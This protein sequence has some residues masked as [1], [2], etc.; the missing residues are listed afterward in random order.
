MGA[1]GKKKK[2]K[3]T[4][5]ASEQ[6]KSLQKK[7]PKPKRGKI[8]FKKKEDFPV[9]GRVESADGM[10]AHQEFISQVPP[11]SGMALAHQ[12]LRK[13]EEK[14][15]TLAEHAPDIIARFD[16]DCRHLYINSRIEEALGISR[17]NILG[18][19]QRELGYPENLVRF[20]NKKI[21]E[22]FS[23]KKEINI[24]Y[25]V[26]TPTGE[27]YFESSLVP[28]LNDRGEVE[29][30]LG[31]SR[32]I[33]HFKETEQKINQLNTRLEEQTRELKKAND[34]LKSFT[35]S[36]SHDLRAPLRSITGF[37]EA[38]KEDYSRSWPSEAKD[39][40][41]RI[42]RASFRMAQLIDSL[43]VLSRVT[44][45]EI[46]VDWID[47]S[48]MAREFCSELRN[49]QPERKV[50]F[51]IQ[52]GL[53]ILGDPRLMDIAVQNLF[54]NAWKFT[55]D[56]S[57]AKIE[58]GVQKEKDKKVFFIKDNGA[59]F[60]MTYADKLFVPFQRLHSMSEFPG[61]GIGLAT[62]QRIIRK[63]NGTIWAEAE[64]GKGATF[65]FHTKVRENENDG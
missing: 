2:I 18:K 1:A 30:V 51:V 49:S 58:F 14:F 7:S 57:P 24:Q 32:D 13:S 8:A 35:Y 21:S 34:E 16:R 55:L 60:D 25:E 48:R 65:Y 15:R 43:L 64:E 47:L 36:V 31:L 26:S 53:R 11:D 28:E 3:K 12:A 50:E 17:E 54:S 59:G 10:K 41:R 37:I 52:D 44:Q 63:H 56:C 45:E 61:A 22:V 5:D 33:T 4:S 27:K 39:Y 40:L 42:D 6:K 9:A 23:K 62:V 20:W 29:T 38:L 19:T 46:K